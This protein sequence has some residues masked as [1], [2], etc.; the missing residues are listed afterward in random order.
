MNRTHDATMIRF[1]LAFG[2]PAVIVGCWI[3]VGL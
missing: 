2:I 3:M 1:I